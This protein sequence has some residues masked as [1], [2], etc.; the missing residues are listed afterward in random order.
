LHLILQLHGK[1]AQTQKR[2]REAG[3]MRSLE[4]HIT[5]HWEDYDAILLYLHDEKPSIYGILTTSICSPLHVERQVKW[6]KK[7]KE[8]NAL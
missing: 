6:R 8:T 2:E 3:Y 1:G 7:K 5:K 4:E